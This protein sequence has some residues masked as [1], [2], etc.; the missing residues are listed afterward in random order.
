MTNYLILRVCVWMWPGSCDALVEASAAR[1]AFY[2]EEVRE[3]R[4]GGQSGLSSQ[5]SLVHLPYPPISSPHHVQLSPD[6]IPRS[7][8]PRQ[9]THAEDLVKEAT[10]NVQTAEDEVKAMVAG[11]T[12]VFERNS[13]DSITGKLTEGAVRWLEDS[14]EQRRTRPS[15]HVPVPL[16]QVS[17]S[18]ATV[19]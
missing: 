9:V 12:T 11:A 1:V 4:S 19:T 3:P 17:P 15:T 7:D 16:A 2:T 13:I 10:A 18:M 8:P 5:P 6:V 14:D